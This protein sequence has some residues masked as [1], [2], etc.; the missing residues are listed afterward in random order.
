ML[1]KGK[2]AIITGTNRGIGRGILEKFAQ[3]G[4]NIWA[5]ARSE[6]K[7]FLDDIEMLSET[8]GVEIQPLCFDLTDANAMKEAMKKVRSEKKPVD[9]LVNNAGIMQDAL[10]GMISR[11]SI[12]QTFAVNVFALLEMTQYIAKLMMRQKSGSIINISSIMGTNGNKGQMVY[13]ASKGAVISA[14]K[15]AA[16]ELADK[17]IRVNAVTPGVI[18]TELFRSVGE[19]QVE[20]KLAKIGMGRAGTPEDVARTCVF[21]AADLSEY[22]TGQII[23][24]DGSTIV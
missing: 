4:A 11:A 16:K 12:E 3:N 5:H 6:T 21:L 19:K 17:N 18:D 2:N 14:T 10:I 20:L 9:V 13:C 22:V 8:Y 7:A 1:L 15:A 24:V 23:G